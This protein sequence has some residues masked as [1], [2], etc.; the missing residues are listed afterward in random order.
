MRQALRD[1]KKKKDE[2]RKPK[3]KAAPKRKAKLEREADMQDPELA[4]EEE[5]LRDAMDAEDTENVGGWQDPWT[6][7]G[8]WSR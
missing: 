7:Q 6:R 1:E 8:S 3:G 5:E 2:E 4:A